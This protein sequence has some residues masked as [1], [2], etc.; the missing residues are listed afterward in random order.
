MSYI[1]NKPVTPVKVI[2]VFKNPNSKKIF[3]Y[4]EENPR[5]TVGEIYEE[6]GIPK[7]F[8]SNLIKDFVLLKVVKFSSIGSSNFYEINKKEYKKFKTYL[9]RYEK[10]KT[11]LDE[12]IP[13]Q[14]KAS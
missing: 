4:I 3:D 10:I 5:A 11:G 1:L 7:S 8:I 12:L 9:N 14:L 6:F 2:K 13:T